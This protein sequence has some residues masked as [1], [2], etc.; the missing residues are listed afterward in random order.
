MSENKQWVRSRNVHFA[1]ILLHF[2][3][4]DKGI[5]AREKINFY[6]QFWKCKSI[7]RASDVFRVTNKYW[8]FCFLA[9]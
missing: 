3:L 1:P 4:Y 7:M 8:I 5:G 9:N 2:L 6:F